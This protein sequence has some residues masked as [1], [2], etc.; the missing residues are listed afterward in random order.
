[1]APVVSKAPQAPRHSQ[2][3]TLSQRAT[4]VYKYQEILTP[5]LDHW[6]FA[7]ARLSPEAS[8]PITR[9]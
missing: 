7:P 4:V 8:Q 1:M 6:L 5:P 2:V 3:K 9:I